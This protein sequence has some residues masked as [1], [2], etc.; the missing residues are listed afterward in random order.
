MWGSKPHLHNILGMELWPSNSREQVNRE[1]QRKPHSVAWEQIRKKEHG[2]ILEVGF[3][4]LSE[5]M[6]KKSKEGARTRSLR[7]CAP[8]VKHS[9]RTAWKSG[10]KSF[11]HRFTGGWISPVADLFSYYFNTLLNPFKL[12]KKWKCKVTKD[13]EDPGLLLLLFIKALEKHSLKQ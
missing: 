6:R 1:I 12:V 5:A 11:T 8:V 7:P 13:L 4:F 2:S 3:H 10:S 9:S